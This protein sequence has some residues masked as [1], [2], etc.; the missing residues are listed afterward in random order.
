ML[1]F[2]QNMT[3]HGFQ[4]F[5]LNEQAVSDVVKI[6]DLSSSTCTYIHVGGSSC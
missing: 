4:E 3:L 5:L 6:A 2:S 1:I